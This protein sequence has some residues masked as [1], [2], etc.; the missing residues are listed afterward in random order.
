MNVD[1]ERKEITDRAILEL[2][3]DKELSLLHSAVA[4]TSRRV[5]ARQYV[6]ASAHACS[7]LPH[8][9]R[10]LLILGEL[11]VLTPEKST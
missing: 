7:A 10:I 9:A 4:D 6:Q 2:D 1:R 11:R 3:L 5:A 8:V